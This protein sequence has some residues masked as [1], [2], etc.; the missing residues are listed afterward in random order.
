MP[1]LDKSIDISINLLE[2]AD[3]SVLG[4]HLEGRIEDLGDLS[5]FYG[6][7][8]FDAEQMSYL[9]AAVYPELVIDSVSLEKLDFRA[10]HRQGIGAIRVKNIEQRLAKERIP[11]VLIE[12]NET[13]DLSLKP[14]NKCAFFLKDAKGIKFAVIN[15]ILHEIDS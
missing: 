11:M 9:E 10:L 1:D 2:V 12:A 13:A 7:S 14:E 3:D 15:G 8:E 6:Y 4:F 5:T